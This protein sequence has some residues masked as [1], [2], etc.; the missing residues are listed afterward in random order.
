[1]TDLESLSCLIEQTRGALTRARLT[2]A[3]L[4]RRAVLEGRGSFEDA[5]A[6][7]ARCTALEANLADAEHEL[8]QARAAAARVVAICAS[9]REALREGPLPPAK[10]ADACNAR[11]VDVQA[12]VQTM[13]RRREVVRCAGGYALAA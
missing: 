10:I 11:R 5:R 1:M 4:W 12:A 3:E 7:D 9:I 2:S 6:A 8:S 13:V